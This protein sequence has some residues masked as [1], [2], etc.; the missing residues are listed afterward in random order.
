MKINLLKAYN[1]G[2]IISYSL[3]F[4]LKQSYFVNDS[5]F[6]CFSKMV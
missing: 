4:D 6:F 3:D 2:S 5:C 1:K